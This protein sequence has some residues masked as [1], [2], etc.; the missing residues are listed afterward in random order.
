MLKVDKYLVGKALEI[1]NSKSIKIVNKPNSKSKFFGKSK[2][3]TVVTTTY[4][5]AITLQ[6][7][8]NSVIG[9]TFSFKQIEFII[10]DDCST[11]DTPN[12]L[13]QKAKEYSNITVVILNENTGT[14]AMPRNI[15]IELATTNK[16]MFLDSDDWLAENAISDL[17]KVM[18][19]GDNDLVVG[20]T[21]KVMDKGESVHAEF[22]SYKERLNLSPF[23]I[24]YLFYH[25]GPPAKLM[26]LSIIKENNIRFP[27][28]RFGEDKFFFFRFLQKSSTVST[29]TNPIYY[30]NR[31]SSN[32]SSLTRTTDVLEKRSVDIDILKYTFDINLPIEQEKSYMKRLVEYDLVKTCDSFLFIKSKQKQKF[33]EY[34]RESL[35]MLAVRPY[36]IIE[37]FDS[38]LYQ[39]AARLI[40]EDKDQDFIALFKWYK[41]DRNKQIVI[42]NGIAYYNVNP[43]DDDHQF[44]I[45][46]LPLFVR[47]KDAYVENDQYVQTVEIYGEQIDKVHHVLIR[48]RNRLENEL[49]VPI[50]IHGNIG[51]FRVDYKDLNMLD[52]SLFTLFVRYD[53]H[54][55]TNIK[56][57]LESQ[58]TYDNR[59]FAFYTTKANN[60]GFLLRKK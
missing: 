11:D 31:L 7:C 48:D 28:V 22:I 39:A 33:I 2:K 13:L 41:S 54:R 24:P 17:V 36:D 5:S 45:I 3:V 32:G 14:P 10:V 56:R 37:T 26:K 53:G 52:N 6:K 59:E 12:I 34:I 25:M 46:P 18:D 49:E 42:K 60:V 40:E 43:F 16:I 29:I 8:I 35:N 4:N 20:K 1:I 50:K 19:E 55:L 21:V 9:Q 57:L 47:A 38:P 30:V 23:E 27:E 44:K 51:E 15:G 58:V